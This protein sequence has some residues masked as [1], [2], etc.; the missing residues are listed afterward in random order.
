MKKN[1][2]NILTK[3]FNKMYSENKFKKTLLYWEEFL[4][5]ESEV[6][7]QTTNRK[8]KNMKIIINSNLIQTETPRAALIKLPKSELKFWHPKKMIRQ[9]GKNNYLTS[10]WFPHNDWKI[11]AQRT[12]AKTRE[13]LEEK[14]YS[15]EE[16]AA[17]YNLKVEK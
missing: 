9:F 3:E 1:V 10:L 12:S 13:V 6:K 15:P 4:N 2:A 5:S 16:M 7:K 8:D 17:T 11:K 14:E